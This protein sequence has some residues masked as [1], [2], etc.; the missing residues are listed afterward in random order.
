MTLKDYQ[1]LMKR[2]YHNQINIYIK[3]IYITSDSLIWLS[4]DE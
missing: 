3:P 1:I 2:Y 4:S